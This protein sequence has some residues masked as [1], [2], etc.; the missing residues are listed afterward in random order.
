MA[1]T[2][3]KGTI[4]PVPD[5]T[6]RRVIHRIGGVD[7]KMAMAGVI[8]AMKGRDSPAAMPVK[9][10]RAVA[11]KRAPEARRRVILKAVQNFGVIKRVPKLS[12]VFAG[13]G[14]RAG[15]MWRLKMAQ[16]NRAPTRQRWGRIRLFEK[17][18]FNIF[19]REFFILP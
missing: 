7:C 3:T 4:P 19:L 11:A 2:T 14:I 13:V 12:M 6:I 9:S 17:G 8:K 18:E 15:P 5:H 1:T 10:A 16:R